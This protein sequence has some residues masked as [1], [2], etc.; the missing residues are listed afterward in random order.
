MNA[1]HPF[2]DCYRAHM[3]AVH[4]PYNAVLH[5][6]I[7]KNFKCTHG[8][9]FNHSQRTVHFS[10]VFAL[11]SNVFAKCSML[12]N[13]LSSFG[14]ILIGI[15]T[16][17]GFRFWNEHINLLNSSYIRVRGLIK[18]NKKCSFSILF[19][20]SAC[21]LSSDLNRILNS[22]ESWLNLC[23]ICKNGHG[24]SS[25]NRINPNMINNQQ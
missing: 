8:P 17:S 19:S 25:L 13:I 12:Q 1:D 24:S 4:L 20:E 9:V 15:E 3:N 21:V 5:N 7:A 16:N 11:K 18:M 23:I 10:S 14:C 22:Y 6:L 2:T